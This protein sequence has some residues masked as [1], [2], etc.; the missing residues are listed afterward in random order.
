[1]GVL[2]EQLK[3]RGPKLR[4]PIAVESVSL[5]E[6]KPDTVLVIEFTSP[7]FPGARYGYRSRVWEDGLGDFGAE[8]LSEYFILEIEEHVEAADMGLPAPSGEPLQWI[9]ED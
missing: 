6:S 4:P 2:Q 8:R 9:A 5:A 3:T 7:A 1:M